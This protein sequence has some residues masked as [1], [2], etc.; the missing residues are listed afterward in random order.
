MDQTE[1]FEALMKLSLSGDKRAYAVLLQETA[2]NMPTTC[3][4]RSNCQKWKMIGRRV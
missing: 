1:N 3:A 2:R 4:T